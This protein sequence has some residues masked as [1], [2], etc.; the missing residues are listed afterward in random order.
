MTYA[1]TLIHRGYEV[2]IH[3]SESVAKKFQERGIAVKS[4]F[5]LDQLTNEGEDSLAQEIAK[6]C[7]VASVAITDVG[8]KFGAIIQK[9]LRLLT[10]V[11]RAAYYDNPEVY[12]PGGIFRKGS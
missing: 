6:A 8:H 10:D 3:T 11:P 1:E 4:T 7:A 12:V 9:A 2:H 5:S